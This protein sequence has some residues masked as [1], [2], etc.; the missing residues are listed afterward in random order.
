[1]YVESESAFT[2]LS[3]L[4]KSETGMVQFR[5][6]NPGELLSTRSFVQ[7]IKSIEEMERKCR[8]L[9]GLLDAR[10]IAVS[11]VVIEEEHA[12]PGD[13]DAYLDEMVTCASEQS[14]SVEGFERSANELDELLSCVEYT[15]QLFQEA[16]KGSSA[17]PELLAGE[18][19]EMMPVV[20]EI[21]MQE[22]DL[23]ARPSSFISGVGNASQALSFERVL[24]R[25]TRGNSILCKETVDDKFHF[26]VFFSAKNI[27]IKTRK[28]CEAFGLRVF[29]LPPLAELPTLQQEVEARLAE[30]IHIA[31][32]AVTAL[33]FTL[34]ALA[35]RIFAIEMRLLDSK[36]VYY[37]LNK[38]QM[39]GGR[40]I[41]TGEF[42][43]P[44]S[45]LPHVETLIRATEARNQVSIQTV[46]NIVLDLEGDGDGDGG[47]GG[48]GGDDHG[49]QEIITPPT[50]MQT[51]KFTKAFNSIV[52]AYAVAS[53][54]EVNPAVF[55]IVTFPFLFGVMFGDVGHALMM[56]IASIVII[57]AERKFE[58]MSKRQL[59]QFGML[60]RARYLVL[61]M[62]V[63][64]LYMGFLY[65][66][67]F[68][69]PMNLESTTWG[70]PPHNVNASSIPSTSTSL[71][72]VKTTNSTFP[73]GVDPIWKVATNELQFYNSLKMKMSIIIAYFHMSL[74]IC[75]HA[76]NAVYF[77][78]PYDLWFEFVPRLV[79]LTCIIGYMVLLIFW[80]WI[81]VWANVQPVAPDML[82]NGASAAPYIIT[83]MT[84]MFLSLT[85]FEPSIDC[86]FMLGCPTQ[87]YI[88]LIL[89]ILAIATVPVM[90]LVK[91]LLLRRDALKAGHSFELGEH[92][93]HQII[94]T[95]EFVLGAISNTA[96]YLRLWALSLAHAELSIVFYDK[97]LI[98]GLKF[99]RDN[100]DIGFL[101]IFGTW[102]I[103]GFFTVGV[104]LGME[105][106]SA[107]LHT[108]RLHWVEFQNKF[109]NL[110]GG[111]PGVKFA[112]FQ[113]EKIRQK[114]FD[115][116]NGA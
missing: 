91:P 31:E 81:T 100:P 113:F 49:G 3:A 54:G 103:W 20:E 62:S 99:G 115:E 65:N 42:W 56:V 107:F 73:F 68:A 44:V 26:V 19:V 86:E 9:R 16:G 89:V 102:A 85:D 67:F 53:Y 70:P 76:F 74:G 93:V 84:N 48:H 59:G 5:D 35:L 63:C 47:G 21:E 15:R 4:G 25:T 28:L 29:A 6:L 18:A 61:L 8:T 96:S 69:I 90:L 72:Y 111:G 64:S 75:M 97:I 12:K 78:R 14:G 36:S 105:G 50:L 60:Y 52:E 38:F 77:S 2:I 33:N 112:P 80:K 51:N 114:W 71:F 34:D 23:P 95:I 55:T 22:D 110:Q 88:Q 58:F 106:L 45:S 98:T 94:E 101:V 116:K 37:E 41:L 87:K 17:P 39:D 83:V 7:E 109:Y 32:K 92:V 40:K 24:W 79:F 30:L 27:E 10:E 46:L 108:L 57:L 11:D 66:E 43:T 1:M 104:L 82:G 13:L